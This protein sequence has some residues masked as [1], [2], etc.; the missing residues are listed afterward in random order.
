MSWPAVAQFLPALQAETPEEYDSYLDVLEA[1]IPER[2]IEAAGRFQQQWPASSLMP[3]IRQLQF[4]AYVNLGNVSDAISAARKAIEST[5]DNQ[6]VRAGL[7][8]ILANTARTD[9]QLNAAQAE[10]RMTLDELN[11]FRPPKSLS[12]PAWKRVEA[13]VRS[14]AHGALG[15]VAFK[16]D[17]VEEAVRQFEMAVALNPEPATQY[18]LGKLYRL[19]NRKEDATKAFRATIAG[20]DPEIRKLAE[21]ELR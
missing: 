2:L 8:L 21:A 13:S 16:R 4:E 9:E 1:P 14:K 19:Q 17:Q 11:K 10:A 15:L 7:A 20:G 5:P 3:H 6:L 12:F 18:R